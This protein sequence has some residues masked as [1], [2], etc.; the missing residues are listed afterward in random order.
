MTEIINL[1][2]MA[3]G[4]LPAATTEEML[5]DIHNE[6]LALK[7]TGLLDLDGYEK[8]KE[9]RK[10]VRS[11]RIDIEQ[12]RKERKA[13]ALE[14]GR[15]LDSEARRL[16]S[17]VVEG[18][19]HL[20]AQMN[21]IDDEKKRREAEAARLAKEQLDSR[22]AQLQQ[23]RAEYHLEAVKTMDDAS[24]AD[25]LACSKTEY[26][27]EQRKRREDQ[28][29]LLQ[30]EAEAKA[31]EKQIAEEEAKN[32]RLQ[33]ELLAQQRAEIAEKEKKLIAERVAREREEAERQAEESARQAAEA[34]AKAAKAKAEAEARKKVGDK[35]LFEQIKIDFPT[36]EVAWIEIARLRKLLANW[37]EKVNG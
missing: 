9:M 27:E 3:T 18:E 35:K 23:Y 1:S 33:E 25:L 24:F 2:E 34:K 7:V 31:R 19:Q 32:K 10:R 11:L 15:R 4:L 37:E 5:L 20:I 22:L 8:C 6:C 30:L 13:D 21:I 28:E 29:R 36:L 14:Y 26:E 16:T 17:V 12:R